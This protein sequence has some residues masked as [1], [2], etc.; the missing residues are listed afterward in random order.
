VEWG[1]LEVLGEEER[2]GVIASARRRRF[3]RR[4]VLFHAGDPG[5]TVHL[6]ASGWVAVYV[7]TPIGNTATFAILGPGE[8]VGEMALLSPAERAAT[9]IAL[10]PTE[11]LSL[12]RDQFDELRTRHPGI[13]RLLVTILADRVRRLNAELVDAYFTRAEVRVLRRLLRV[14]RAMPEREGR[15]VV[16]LTQEDLAGLAGTSRATVNRTLR[17]LEAEGALEQ[18]RGRI[19]VLDLE[20]LAAR[21]RP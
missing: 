13:D 1:L 14:A 17:E 18:S 21:A 5:D 20:L 10:E 16:R 8:A 4:E 11:T 3:S 15:R 7:T 9:A 6:I 2:R 19:A 12:R